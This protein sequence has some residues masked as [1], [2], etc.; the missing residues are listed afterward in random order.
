VRLSRINAV[1]GLAEIPRELR[2]RWA[3]RTAGYHGLLAEPR[4]RGAADRLKRWWLGVEGRAV[5]RGVRLP[6]GRT[7]L[8]LCRAR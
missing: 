6:V 5:A 1:L 3:S 7:I 2:A 8:S 4:S